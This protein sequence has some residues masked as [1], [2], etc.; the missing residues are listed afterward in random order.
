MLIL[1]RRRNE[2]IC[3][4]DDI[5]VMVSDIRGDKVRIGITAPPEVPVHRYEV[6]NAIQREQR[7][8]K[9]MIQKET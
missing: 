3:I 7:E 1:S 4:G 6:W 2:V 5:T 8:K 9:E